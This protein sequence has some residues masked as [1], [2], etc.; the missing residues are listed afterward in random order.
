MSDK[1][2]YNAAHDVRLRETMTAGA[3]L[4]QPKVMRYVKPEMTKHRH[5]VGLVRTDTLHGMIQVW[6]PGRGNKLHKHPNVDGLWFVL[7]GR[8]VFYTDDDQLVAEL[9]P[10]ES[11]LIPRQFPHRIESIGDNDLEIL[12]VEALLTPGEQ[13]KVD[14]LDSAEVD[15]DFDVTYL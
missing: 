14:L 4:V 8:A 6:K 3:P 7:A 10:G 2:M 11:I 1:A 5:L 13:I 12:Q 9:G 15:K